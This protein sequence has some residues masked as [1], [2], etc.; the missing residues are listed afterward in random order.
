MNFGEW[1]AV[2]VPL[3]KRFTIEKDAKI[4]EGNP[5]AGKIAGQLLRQ[6]Y[7]QQEVLQQAVHEIARLELLLM[8][9]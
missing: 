4:L 9:T 2:E 8:Q 1:M 7:Y 6:C 5:E 3:E